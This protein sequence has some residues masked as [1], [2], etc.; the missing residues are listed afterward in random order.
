[1]I[2]RVLHIY[3]IIQ[4]RLPKTY[5]SPS[6][7]FY[8]DEKCL[9]RNHIDVTKKND[10]SIY[11]IVDPDTYTIHMPLKMSFEYNINNSMITRDVKINQ[12]SDKQIALVIL[13]ELGHLYFGKRYGYSS[14]QYSNENMCD[15]FA[16]RWFRVLKKEQLL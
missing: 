11:A 10:E 6:L 14:K 15:Q 9:M 7:A 2:K 16:Y 3:K 12:V 8:Q 4:K 13:H 1:M 5:P